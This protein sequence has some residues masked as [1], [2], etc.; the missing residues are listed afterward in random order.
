[1]SDIG[2]SLLSIKN[3]HVISLI[4][5]TWDESFGN[6]KKLK[7]AIINRGWYLVNIILSDHQEINTVLEIYL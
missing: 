7:K 2:I 3:K 6:F 5:T 4:N 1:M